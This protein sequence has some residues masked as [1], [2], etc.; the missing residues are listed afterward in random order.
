[1]MEQL[2][3]NFL[4]LFVLAVVINCGTFTWAQSISKG[5]QALEMYDYF[6]SK[7]IFEKKLKK[8]TS[9]AA[10]GLAQIYFRNNNPF[11][12]IDSAHRYVVLAIDSYDG[13]KPKK[14]LKLQRFGYV[15]ESLETLRQDVSNELFHRA[16][17]SD[18]EASY[19]QF[20]AENFWATQVPYA[21]F[22]RDSCA[23]EYAFAE[24]SSELIKAFMEKYPVS[25]F[26]S[27]ALDL[28]YR[29]QFE[30]ETAKGDELGYVAFMNNF[31]ENPYKTE[32]ERTVFYM[33]EQ[34]NTIQDFEDYISKYP[35]SVHVDQAWVKLYRLFIRENGLAQLNYFKTLYPNYPFLDQLETEISLLRTQLYAFV[36]EE[37]W[38]FMD[39]QGKVM[40]EPQFTFVDDFSQGRA[41]VFHKGNYGFIE[42]S[43]KWIIEPQFSAVLPFYFNMSVVYDDAGNAGLI[44]LFGEWIVKPQYDDIIIVNDEKVW[45]VQEDKVALFKLKSMQMSSE[46]YDDFLA[47]PNGLVIVFD[48]EIYAVINQ[49][50]EVL[51]SYIEEIL[52]FGDLFVVTQNDSMAIVDENNKVILPF[53]AY[54][55]S[56]FN[57][58]GLTPFELNG[59]L[60][61]LNEDGE[62]LIAPT[63]DIFPNWNLFANFEAGNAKA[64]QAKT[65]KYGLINE[66]GKWA[67]P[68]KYEDISFYSD[69]IAV[70]LNGK[71]EF[72]NSLG[73][74]QNLG[75]FDRAESFRNGLAIV[76]KNGAQGL[77]GQNGNYI[78]E[79]EMR[80]IVFLTEKVLRWI[81]QDGELQIGY[82]T[83]EILWSKLCAKIEW[84]NENTIRIITDSKVQYYLIDEE[85]FISVKN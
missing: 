85:R 27:R 15:L 64:F 4:K 68:P 34:M 21:V 69:L 31:P 42:P 13:Y 62:I 77:I 74:K 52:P 28:F 29:F 6:R 55:I 47:C 11:H 79:P 76:Q 80:S 72:V 49:N 73:T 30:E 56:G 9:P 14:Q 67:I 53:D 59:K 43:G 37:L 75:T 83:G 17:Q 48:G 45:V 58:N 81:N 84:V 24:H 22:L 1:M 39:H 3:V 32:A 54:T 33:Y 2:K 78:L 19:S 25:A 41:A 51:F 8:E 65:K 35:N 66:Q 82:V 50:E 71:W 7:K 46:K 20:I 70:Q 10:Y 44:N 18:T 40:I 38:G 60:G 63:L 61:Y 36:Q 57:K 16:R 12:N 23:F 26:E 5:F